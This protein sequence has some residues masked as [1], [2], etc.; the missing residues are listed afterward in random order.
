MVKNDK[1][2]PIKQEDNQQDDQANTVNN[3]PLE[4]FANLS[5]PK[6]PVR[7]Q[8]PELKKIADQVPELDVDGF[9]DSLQLKNATIKDKDYSR[10]VVSIITIIANHYEYEFGQ[11]NGIGYL[12]VDGYWQKISD[13]QLFELVRFTAIK[14]KVPVRVY[15]RSE[16]IVYT[17]K[18]L[19]SRGRRSSENP[20]TETTIINFKDET[21]F[22]DKYGNIKVDDH[23]KDDFIKYKLNYNYD[24]EAT[25]PKWEKFLTQVIRKPNDRGRAEF[26]KDPSND[27]I[28]YDTIKVIQ[29]YI[30]YCFSKS[31]RFEKMLICTGG[32]SNG[33]SVFFNVIE[34][35]IGKANMSTL[36]L[37]SINIASLR[38][39]MENK[40]VNF[41]SEIGNTKD[42]NFD[43]I[44]KIVSGE[45]ILINPKYLQ[46]YETRTYGKLI[47]NGN[48]LLQRVEHSTAFFRRFIIIQFLV[49]IEDKNKE[50]NLAEELRKELPGIMNWA[51]NGLK[52]LNSNKTGFTKSKQVDR[53]VKEYQAYMDNVHH[54][55]SEFNIYPAPPLKKENKKWV[56][57]D[58]SEIKQ[59]NDWKIIEL[60]DESETLTRQFISLS[61]LM[62]KSETFF[63]ENGYKKISNK[64]LKRRMFE[65]W[66]Y[67]FYKTRNGQML[68]IYAK[69]KVHFQSDYKVSTPQPEPPKPRNSQEDE[70]PF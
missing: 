33:K 25:C 17:I 41:S 45:P 43:L 24:P 9:R 7:V 70:L 35:L 5:T 52:R 10:G 65:N 13:D 19:L 16:W 32:G 40:L 1:Q 3:V 18:E 56:E 69:D 21:V 8:H 28:D 67:D 15:D 36:D 11:S 58:G 47:F 60:Y 31:F 51:I 26:V 50:Y 44:K 39:G 59:E 27:Q 34:S 55:L 4:L 38:V 2:Q 64:E 57:L 20:D 30:G 61:E 68:W 22:I 53:T 63:Y 12:Y 48:S 23:N 46:P 37:A 14:S 29:E 49:N 62:S 6:D 54:F 66:G 42:L